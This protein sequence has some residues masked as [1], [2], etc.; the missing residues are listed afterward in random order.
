MK[1]ESFNCRPAALPAMITPTTSERPAKRSNSSTASSVNCSGITSSARKMLRMAA[2]GLDQR[3]VKW[4]RKNLHVD[5]KPC[6]LFQPALHI[7][8]TWITVHPA[9]HPHRVLPD[10]RAVID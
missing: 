4:D 9:D 8:H 10:R 3:A 2:G 1:A 7:D 5:I 6:H